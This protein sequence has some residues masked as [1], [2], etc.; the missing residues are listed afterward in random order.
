MSPSDAQLTTWFEEHRKFLWGLSYRI[1]GSA[2]D[3]DD[4]VQETF[5]RALQHAPAQLDDPRRWLVKVAVN[6]AR[7]LLRRRKRRGYIGQWLPT[8]IETAGKDALPSYEPAI[9]GAQTSEGRYDLMESVSL[10]FLQALEALT[11]TQRAVLL[12]S[13]VFDYSASEVSKALE[14]SEGNARIIHHRARKAMASY[15]GQRS[16]PTPSN[17]QRTQ[18]ALQRFLDLLGV[19]DVHGIER[20]LAGDIVALTDGGGQFTATR[21]PIAGPARVARFFARLAASRSGLMRIAFRTLNGFPAVVFD[22]EPSARGRRAPRLVL[23]ADVNSAG[24]IH[25]LR[26]ITNP[27]KLAAVSPLASTA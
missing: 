14:M 24:Q 3:A 18:Q 13:D 1:T 4:V 17:Q 15:D 21:R 7:D 10:A 9:D 20:M 16:V 8:P 22:F 23:T 12:L 27:I 11:P 26:A 6:A 2:A 5:V 19:G 25:R